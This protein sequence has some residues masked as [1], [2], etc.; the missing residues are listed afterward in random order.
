MCI[1]NS[2]CIPIKKYLRY[3]G[4]Y[5]IT[6]TTWSVLTGVRGWEGQGNWLPES[7]RSRRESVVNFLIKVRLGYKSVNLSL[8]VHMHWF[9]IIWI[10]PFPVP[11]APE[12]I[13]GHAS[14]QYYYF[15]STTRSTRTIHAFKKKFPADRVLIPMFRMIPDL[16]QLFV[17]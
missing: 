17:Y 2:V 3:F 7:Q 10:P 4:R 8:G 1:L 12:I 11:C 13:N 6:K 14:T 16:I 9:F 15:S 5:P